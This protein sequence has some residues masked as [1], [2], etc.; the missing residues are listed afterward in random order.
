[1]NGD[2]LHFQMLIDSFIQDLFPDQII[3]N[4]STFTKS[5][6]EF[7]GACK[8]MYK[9]SPASLAKIE[10][11]ER[12]YTSEKAIDWYTQDSFIYTLLNRA[13]RANDVNWILIF[14]FLII[15]LYKQLHELCCEPITEEDPFALSPTYHVYRGQLIT[16]N[17]LDT[18]RKGIGNVISMK[19]FLSTSLD[20]EQ[21]LFYLGGED[22]PSSSSLRRVLIEIDLGPINCSM[23]FT[24]PFANITE[25]SFFGDT[26]KEVLFMIGSYFRVVEV[27]RG[28]SGIWSIFLKAINTISSSLGIYSRLDD[29]E[30]LYSHMGRDSIY[31]MIADSQDVGLI[32]LQSGEFDVA[33]IYYE[34]V[35]Q[36]VKDAT[37]LP[38]EKEDE[39]QQASSSGTRN[40]KTSFLDFRPGLLAGNDD[41]DGRGYFE[42]KRA[43]IEAYCFWLLGRI[44]Y[45]KGLLD[46]SAEYYQAVLKMVT[47]SSSAYREIGEC[48]DHNLCAFSHLA[49]GATYES[50]GNLTHAY[51]SYTTAFKMFE[52]A[53][54]STKLIHV[55]EAHC[56]VGF[57]NLCFIEKQFDQANEHYYKALLLFDKH[58]PA[59][60]PDQVRVRQKRARI[61]KVHQRQP[62][63]ALEDYQDCLESYLTSLPSDHVDIARLYTDMA[64]TYEQ[65]PNESEKALE[66]ARKAAN[67]FEKRLPKEHT[68]NVAIG[69]I[70][71][72]IQ[73]NHS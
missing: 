68:D 33:Q 13:L 4:Y 61:V 22:D 60:H 43:Y 65:L 8:E 34:R 11:F 56:L 20:R 73:R 9:N 5:K 72:R 32:L 69:L 54:D 71:E 45:E 52:Y 51:E 39:Q 26:E 1:M 67:I 38:E 36:R 14:R 53:H 48:K 37:Y 15:D 12:T 24:K 50:S 64:L 40:G 46:S 42:M 7:I 31:S 57:G 3:D 59:R 17:E 19:S 30:T 10:E 58:L 16:K 62:A 25:Y 21:A 41:A 44:T 55:Y 27:R 47:P 29:M 66:L 6:E 49:L 35:L 70:V 28:E 18:I 23:D 2:L 63:A